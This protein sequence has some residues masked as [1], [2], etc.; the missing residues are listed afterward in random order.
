MVGLNI[1]STVSFPHNTFQTGEGVIGAVMVTASWIHCLF[2]LK[3]YQNRLSRG[4]TP[5]PAKKAY[6]APQTP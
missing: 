2:K 4:S 3:M 6:D 1:E 5:D